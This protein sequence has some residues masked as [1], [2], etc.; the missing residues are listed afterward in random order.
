MKLPEI[1]VK[2][3]VFTVMVFMAVLLFGTIT[4]FMLPE[5]VLPD[6]ELPTLTVITVYPGA[7]SNEVEQQV[8]RKLEEVLSGCVNLKSVTSRSRENVSVISLQFQWNSDINEAAANA[9]DMMELA[10]PYLPDDARSPIIMKINSSLLPVLVYGVSSRESY[11]GIGKIIDEKISNRLKKLPGVGNVFIIGQPSREISVRVNPEKLKAYHLN[12]SQLSQFLKQENM[13]IPGGSMQIGTA[14]F[15]IRIP[16]DIRNLDDLRHLQITT[17]NG[18]Q[19]RLGDVAEISDGIKETNEILRVS[20]KRS[21]G[22]MVQKQSGAN[23]LEV[24]KVLEEEIKKIIPTLPAD[25]RVT[26]VLNTTDLVE[27][28]INNLTETILYAGLF[29]VV[30]V[31]FFLRDYRSSL[32]IILTIPFSLITAFIYMYFAGFT[33]NMFSLMSLAIAIGLVVDNAIVVL[34]NISRHIEKGVKPLQAAIFATGEMGLAITASTLTIIAV[35]IPLLFLGG[36]AGVMFRQLAILTSITL[37]ASLVTSLWLTPMMASKMLKPVADMRRRRG[38]FYNFG[39]RVFTKIE[40]GYKQGLAWSVRHRWVIIGSSLVLFAGTLFLS[41]RIG[42]DYIPPI[43]AGDI[44]IV[45]QTETG[46]STKETERV[47]IEVEKILREEVPE[48]EY[49]FTVVGQTETGLLSSIGFKEGKN[50]TTLL[51][52]MVPPEDRERSSEEVAEILRS[53]LSRVPEIDRFNV[54]GGSFL[55]SM[56]LGNIKPIEIRI[57]G[58][59]LGELNNTADS[60]RNELN[61]YSWLTNVET[62]SDRGKPEILIRIDRDRA[63]SIGLSNA[64]VASQIRQG[65]FGTESGSYAEAGD[66]YPIVIRYD[67]SRRSTLS[68]LQNILLNTLT[69]QQVSLGSVAVI[70]E[71]SGQLEIE[72]ESQ[73]R[74]VRVTADPKNISLGDA[75]LRVRSVIDRT[76]VP[77]NVTVSLGGQ[78]TEQSDS[79][80]GL[81][82]MLIAGI[83]LIYMIMAAQFESFRDPFIIMFTVPLSIIGVVWAFY[84]TGVTLSVITFV[85]LIMLVGIDVNNGIIL[86]DYTN[87]LRKRGSTLLEA[88]AEAGKLR[89]RPVLMTS[90]I[91]IL[92]FIPM[93]MSDGMGSEIWS[94]LGITCIGGLLVSKLFTMFLIPVLYVSFNRKTL[95][96]ENNLLHV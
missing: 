87:L 23:S 41:G 86:V 24:A 3:P 46:T 26:K 1:G 49:Y 60:L 15:A 67:S 25:V 61:R 9:R 68:D 72:R 95:R 21:V 93:A 90:L 14:D 56:L 81:L 7:S 17:F 83:L 2:R 20:D 22:L 94:P 35:F 38:G 85:G 55:F 84:L 34:D 12:I 10:M 52:K 31:F 13:D 16:G 92:G 59:D 8:T 88:A 45:F 57:T 19:I 75:I 70:T 71:G 89:L 30:I 43:D 91:A 77:E 58:S 80:T 28:S 69:G 47:A 79:F 4:L 11:Q 64:M 63:G 48:M 40:N 73:E 51:A 44:T 37:L 66:D 96:H 54:H 5:D 27:A 62:T 76:P 65:I 29:V 32:I 74:I 50:T 36:L 78:A 6:I 18:R 33:I 42:T 82:A 39:E 53:R